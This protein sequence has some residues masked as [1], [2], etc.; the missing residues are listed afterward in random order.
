MSDG[1]LKLL[2][3]GPCPPP[4]GGISVH[5]ATAHQ[6]LTRSGARCRVLD[7]AGRRAGRARKRPSTALVRL[8]R[9]WARV[10]H[11]ACRGWSVHVHTNGHNPKSWLVVLVCGLAARRAPGRMVT[12]HSGMVP[13]YLAGLAWRRGLA[14]LALASYQRV[15]CVNEEIRQAVAALGL[16]AGRLE[17]AP[18]YLATPPPAT[19]VPE[20]LEAWL[21]GCRPLLTATLF[22]RP[23][24]GF[25]V[26]LA[27]LLRLKERHPGLGCLVMGSGE[28]EEE[29]A[30][31]AAAG[32][33]GDWVVLPGD[34]SHDLCLTLIS[35]SDL[36]VRP[37]LVDG[38]AL[39]V[40][41]ALA[42]GV[43]VV[44]SDTG[45]R[46]PG[47]VLFTP[48]DERE[49][50]A[51]AEDVLLAAEAPSAPRPSSPESFGVE[52]LLRTYRD[53]AAC[54]GG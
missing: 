36:F 45:N 15:L 5:V 50:A 53:I 46:P 33:L 32:E 31:R 16:A 6:L 52:R 22:F 7:A 29:A 42:L 40:R 25:E 21:A 27:A 18:A 12:L 13:A 20:P 23:E 14:R 43:Q 3:I 35:R 9:L 2:L 41:E 44:A 34:L 37:T 48:G 24:Y 30:A 17:V 19:P 39:S 4:H 10:R 47:S 54:G 1:A 11:H 28:A 38:D 26:L 49:L 51:V 8:A